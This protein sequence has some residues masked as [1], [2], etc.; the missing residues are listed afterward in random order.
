MKTIS[1]YLATLLISFQI[2]AASGV[3][4]NTATQG[5]LEALPGIGEKKAKD[6]IAHR[7][8]HSVDEL[9]NVKGIGDKEF[10]KLK[11]LVVVDQPAAPVAEKAPVT[12]TA[13][14]TTTTT[15]KQP[16]TK[17]ETT[18]SASKTAASELAAG[19]KIN[20]NTA[21]K[22]DLERL[23]GIGE[24]KA[25]AIIDARPFQKPEDVMK[26]KGIKAK[27]YDKI[28]DHIAL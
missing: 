24:T 27:T 18:S 17:K 11:G 6:I 9:K 2:F 23:P 1:L 15:T 8:F 25:Q 5:E 20:L 14:T 10:N 13:P 4:L 22:Q 21:S 19:E 3:N 12:E 7:P 28:K 16:E 26:V